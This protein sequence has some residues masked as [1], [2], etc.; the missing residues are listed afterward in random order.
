M[1]SA[2]TEW[3]SA[4]TEIAST[5]GLGDVADGVEGDAARG[6]EAGAPG[7]AADRLPERCRRHVVEQDDLGAGRRALR[8]AARACRPRPRRPSPGREARAAAIAAATPPAT[9][10]WLSLIRM[11]SYSPA[12]WLVPPPQATALLVELA[13]SRGG[14]AR[15]QELHVRPVDPVGVGRVVVAI[16]ELRC[17]QVECG[18]LAGQQ[19]PEPTRAPRRSRRAP[20][21]ARR[22]RPPHPLE[23]RVRV[24]RA[25]H[26][27]RLVDA[28]DHAG[29]AHD[30]VWRR[31]AAPRARSHRVVMSPLTDVL[32]ERAFDQTVR[33]SGG[34]R[35]V[36]QGGRL[37]REV[38]PD[39]GTARSHSGGERRE[40]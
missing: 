32:G 29:L 3:V 14:L 27:E 17:K 36:G 19:R 39:V 12:R 22:P 25:E 28:A 18:A 11:A 5:P 4:P 37:G 23:L 20:R 10:T 7:R 40:R 21:S 38:E 31:P 13:Q 15:V 16:P 34:H 1:S 33:C 9:A 2:R 24:E 6:F 8:R 35:S 26:R 30:H